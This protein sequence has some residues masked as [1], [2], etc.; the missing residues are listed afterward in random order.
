M[1]SFIFPY[2]Q[3]PSMRVRGGY[4]NVYAG[5][6]YGLV[7]DLRCLAHA[8]GWQQSSMGPVLYRIHIIPKRGDE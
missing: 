8:S 5:P 2:P 4:V 3:H 6:V 1:K 7:H